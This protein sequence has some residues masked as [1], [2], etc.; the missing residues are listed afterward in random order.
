M[1]VYNGSAI[2]WG[3]TV[4]RF[5]IFNMLGYNGSYRSLIGGLDLVYTMLGYNGF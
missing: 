1:L 3:T 5:N 4:P 2:C